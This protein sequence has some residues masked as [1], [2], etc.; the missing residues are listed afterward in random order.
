CSVPAMINTRTLADDKERAATIRVIPFF[1]C[2]AKLPILTA[3]AG[4]VVAYFGVGNADLI[5]YGM[6]LLGITSA[7]L[8]VLFMRNTTLK[9]ETPPFIMELPAYHAPQ[10][11]NLMAHLWD[12]TKHFVKKAFTIIVASTIVIWVLSHFSFSWH[13][14]EDEQI[15]ESILAQIS[16]FVQPIFTPLGFGSQLGKF[17]WV[18]VVAAISGLIAKE[19]VIATFA[20]L[21]ACLAAI[22]GSGVDLAALDVEAEEGIDAVQ[23]MIAATGIGIPGLIA[24]IAFNMTT[25]PCFAAVGTA[26]AELMNSKSY[27]GTLVFWVV[28]SF[29]VAAAI[30]TI[31][32]WW[33]TAFIWAVA[34]ALTVY[35]VVNYNKKAN[36]VKKQ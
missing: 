9:G 22:A 27:K 19:N 24:F 13:F 20:T 11:K 25:I 21:A 8:A 2:G 32:S 35:F 3:V 17:G 15:S 34:V 31:G 36:K 4:A 29:I 18:F 16:M 30:Y 14:L 28:S 26:K 10:F 7:I 23:A 33:W 12:K 1:S 6:Y 5:T